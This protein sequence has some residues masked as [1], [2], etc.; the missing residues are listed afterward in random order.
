MYHNSIVRGGRIWTQDIFIENI[1]MCQLS[2][3]ALAKENEIYH[4][5]I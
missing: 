5:I 3:K 1:R 2:Y 4:N